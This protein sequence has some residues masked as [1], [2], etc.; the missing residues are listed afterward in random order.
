MIMGHKHHRLEKRIESALLSRIPNPREAYFLH[1][2][3]ER[4]LHHGQNTRLSDRQAEWLF[5]ILTR[6][7][8]KTSRTPTPAP[9]PSPARKR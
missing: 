4:I 8:A 5:A 3:S 7:E 1:G 9:G 2:M 6:C